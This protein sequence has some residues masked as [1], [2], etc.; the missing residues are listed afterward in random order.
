MYGIGS[1]R[2]ALAICLLALLAVF[3]VPPASGAAQDPN[4]AAPDPGGAAPDPKETAQDR[5]ALLVDQMIAR[6]GSVE[7]P[8]GRMTR[9][10]DFAMVIHYLS[11]E[12]KLQDAID[13][14]KIDALVDLL[15][16][17]IEAEDFSVAGA[18][19]LIGPRAARAGPALQA[20]HATACAKVQ[21]MQFSSG[22]HDVDAFELALERITGTAPDCRGLKLI[23]Q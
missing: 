8:E 10:E 17:D 7:S 23:Q 22:I 6:I 19:G 5:T 13:D 9:A 11:D 3:A 1:I 21:A 14:A 12:D 18:L 16:D 20:A 15:K 4:G 2:K